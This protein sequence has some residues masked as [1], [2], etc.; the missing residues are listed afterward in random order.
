M[1]EDDERVTKVNAQGFAETPSKDE[2]LSL[3]GELSADLAAI[4]LR[5]ADMRERI[6]MITRRLLKELEQ[7]GK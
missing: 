2:W 7:S 1:R 3:I 5:A 4:E 6:D